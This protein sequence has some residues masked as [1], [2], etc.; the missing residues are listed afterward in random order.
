MWS[1]HFMPRQAPYVAPRPF[2]AWPP[3]ATRRVVAAPSEFEAPQLDTSLYHRTVFTMPLPGK[4]KQAEIT[5]YFDKA[6]LEEPYIC[7][8][9]ALAVLCDED[10]PTIQN[11]HGIFISRAKNSKNEKKKVFY[12]ILNKLGL[13]RTSKHYF[14][15]T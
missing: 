11:A 10:A 5:I 15:I 8:G 4:R 3:P 2:V 1:H 7:N 6:T 9:Q 12:L 14:S 13:V